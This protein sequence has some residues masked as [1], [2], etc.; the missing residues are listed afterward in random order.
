MIPRY[1]Q[2]PSPLCRLTWVVTHMIGLHIELTMLEEC[3]VASMTILGMLISNI[4]LT[5]DTRAH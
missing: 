1:L 2:Y 4:V 5:V 3:D